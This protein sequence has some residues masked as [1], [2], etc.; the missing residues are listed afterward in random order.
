MIVGLFCLGL[1]SCPLVDTRPVARRSPAY[2]TGPRVRAPLP[3]ATWDYVAKRGDTLLEIARAY[4]VSIDE[5][6]RL[7]RIRDPDLLL[8]GQHLR[9]PVRPPDSRL[10]RCRRELDL[11]ERQ[12]ADADFEGAGR[13][14]E[15]V[16]RQIDPAERGSTDLLIRLE[17][18]NAN[19]YAAF[20]DEEQAT[21]SFGRALRL[22]PGYA[23]A[24]R[25]SPKVMRAFE[26]AQQANRAQ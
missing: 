2:E 5:I 17:E 16:R 18:I 19:V 15:G 25:I 22:D 9:I 7:N 1:V 13:R 11:A 20:G 24:H 6:I 10:D 8:V 3:A 23:P 21:A 12:I 26:Q 14:L 4:G